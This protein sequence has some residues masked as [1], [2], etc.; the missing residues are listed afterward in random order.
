MNMIQCIR[1][2]E[3][4]FLPKNKKA[5]QTRN[6]VAG[7]IM[8]GT[9]ISVLTAL[10]LFLVLSVLISKELLPYDS[11]PVLMLIGTAIASFAG[12]FGSA[13]GA[14]DKK[15]LT[16]LVSAVLYTGIIAAASAAGG[17]SPDEGTAIWKSLLAGIVPSVAA[18]T[19]V[20]SRKQK[21][22]R[23]G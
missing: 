7:C 17:I 21:S 15:I 2:Q 4:Y 18:S 20:V 16:A 22:K 13:S 14:P 19:V 8:K 5:R 9:I 23:K 11:Q 6:T 1:L 10:V 12:G 3:V